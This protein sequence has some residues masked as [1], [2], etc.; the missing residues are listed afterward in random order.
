MRPKL[1]ALAV[2]GMVTAALVGGT[3]TYVSLDKTVTVSVDGHLSKVQT[4]ASSVRSVLHR[5]GVEVGVHDGVSPALTATVHDGETIQ[6]ERGRQLDLNIDGQ[7]R[8]VWVTASSVADA[9]QQIGLRTQGAVVSA[10]R[11][12]RVPLVGMS[13]D[14]ELPHT[15]SVVVD[16]QTHALV[17]AKTTV[18]AALTAADIVLNPAD[19][20]SVPLAAR[21][22]DGMSIVIVRV[23]TRQK[24]QASAIAFT[25]TTKSDPSSY[26]GTKNVVQQGKNGTLV[27]T[28]Q[29]TFTNGAQTAIAMVGRRVSVAPVAQIIAVGTKPRPVPVARTFTVPSDGLN[30]AGLAACESGGRANADNGRYYGLYQFSLGTWRDVGGQGLPSQASPSEQTYRAQLLYDRTS[31]RSQWPVC[32]S[33]LFS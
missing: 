18:A 33:R 27:R 24:L 29:L 1:V 9:L 3:A 2:Y 31:W 8:E 10:D 14:I 4:F 20:I 19:Q 25:T 22:T 21:P 16:G 6:I 15:I 32:G 26:V 23:A 13:I 7:A 28:Y 12:T 11:S 17:T 5:A 30:W